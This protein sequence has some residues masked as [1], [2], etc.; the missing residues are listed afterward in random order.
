MS[1][2]VFEMWYFTVNMCIDKMISYWW[3]RIDITLKLSCHCWLSML[4]VY[5]MLLEVTIELTSAIDW[6]R[7]SFVLGKDWLVSQF[8]IVVF[9][10]TLLTSLEYG[11]TMWE[12]S[13]SYERFF[14]NLIQGMCFCQHSFCVLWLVFYYKLSLQ[15]IWLVFYYKLE[16]TRNPL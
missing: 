12:L 1:L 16:F 13:N 9:L 14:C 15:L 5:L 6:N 4:N 2:L 11:C 3:E 8:L 10:L 7:P